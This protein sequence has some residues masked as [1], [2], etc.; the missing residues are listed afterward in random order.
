MKSLILRGKYSNFVKPKGRTMKTLK[1]KPLL[2]STASVDKGGKVNNVQQRVIKL[3]KVTIVERER[4]RIPSYQ[5][6]LP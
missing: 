2:M 3:R 1:D 6:L 4:L 5:Y